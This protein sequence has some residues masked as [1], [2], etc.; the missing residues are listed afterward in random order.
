VYVPIPKLE[1]SHDDTTNK[2]EYT[3]NYDIFLDAETS[4]GLYQIFAKSK[5]PHTCFKI[6]ITDKFDD[7]K[8]P[9]CFKVCENINNKFNENNLTEDDLKEIFKGTDKDDTGNIFHYDVSECKF[10]ELLNNKVND[11]YNEMI[12]NNNPVTKFIDDKYN[13]K[14]NYKHFSALNVTTTSDNVY[15]K[16]IKSNPSDKIDKI[17]LF[18]DQNGHSGYNLFDIE[19]ASVYNSEIIFYD[20]NDQPIPS[21]LLDKKYGE[22]QYLTFIPKSFNEIATINICKLDECNK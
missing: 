2:T 22:F 13:G 20:L 9:Y 17:V 8:I 21:G 1:K 4:D 15:Y 14:I 18:N 16:I 19:D 7:D 10:L 3:R 11:I 5:N 12:N 6:T